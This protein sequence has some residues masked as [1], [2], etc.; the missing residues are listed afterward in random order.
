LTVT[1][2]DGSSPL[3][4]NFNDLAAFD[5]RDTVTLGNVIDKINAAD[6]TRLKAEISADGDRIVLTDLTSDTGGTF[7]VASASG[8]TLA[9]ELGIATSAGA[10]EISGRRLLSG[11]K[12][13]LVSSLNGGQ[14]FT[15]GQLELE[16]RSGATATV[17]LSSAET[18]G[19]VVS[20]INAAS[21][22]ITARVNRAGNGIELVDSSG[23]T[24]NLTIASGDANE[25][26][27]Q[28]NIAVDA[29][30]SSINSGSLHRQTVSRQTKLSDFN[31]GQGVA[32]GRF[33][34]TNS[35]GAS[36]VITLTGTNATH[37]G[38]VLDLINSA[39]VGVTASINATGDGIQLTDTA[40]GTGTLTVNASG[41]KS[42][43]D[44]KI[45]GVAKTVDVG[46]TPTQVID[47]STAVTIEIS[48]EDTL[49]DL[50]EKIND[51]G[52]PLSASIFSDGSP[53]NPFRLSLTS[54]VSGE[55]GRFLVD[56]SAAG[57]ALDEIVSAQD[58][59]LLF[60]SI[61]AGGIVATSSNGVFN[62]LVSGVSLS[63]KGAST[64]PVTITIAG[65]DA[66]F[67][68][69][70]KSLVDQYNKLHAKIK[71]QTAF[72]P[73]TNSTGILFGSNETLRI[74]S[75]LSR[76]FTGRQ[77]GL[78]GVASL[79]E[80]GLSVNEDGSLALDEAK[81]KSQFAADPAGVKDFFLHETR[82]FAG[83]L[84]KLTESFVNVDNSL[85]LNRY[86]ALSR[87]VD[88]NQERIERLTASLDRQ[89]EA[90]LMQFYN[91][92]SVIAKLQDSL[93]AVQGI[94]AIPPL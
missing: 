60:G 84:D 7:S 20:I 41:K 69:G 50:V 58:A 29:A 42:A 12:D 66:T 11:L 24:G 67:V 3:S 49:E 36:A 85:L 28:L 87:K 82:G 38:D 47:G 59:R 18:L 74:E 51:A 83:K 21:V 35:Q 40:G 81:L 31:G 32:P 8:G 5:K 2:Q 16:D 77:S 93:T 1:F 6:A 33:T 23:G 72:D 91:M 14:G 15:L 10:D 39:G 19:D 86:T 27:E 54:T 78:D 26:A 30:Q 4:I 89:R 76:L 55:A 48:A 68:S 46:G 61:S 75:E 94:Q 71:S 64:E 43:L 34:I 44:L 80:L 13:T 52:L 57:F 70:V 17:D 22:D 90:L 37:I 62:D 45:A 79:A 65:T 88:F 25:S 73:E 92:E 9:E 53:T 56:T 63:V